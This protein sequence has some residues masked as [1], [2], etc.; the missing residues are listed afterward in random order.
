[1]PKPAHARKAALATNKRSKKHGKQPS[2]REQ[3]QML[4]MAE[5]G[6]GSYVIGAALGRAPNTVHKYITQPLFSDPKF[7]QLV[8]EY[9]SKELID[10]T[11]L[12]IE[13][14]GRLHDLV[15]TMTPIEAIALMDKS[16]TQRRLLEGKSTENIF[17][18]RKII[19]EAH[20]AIQVE[21]TSTIPVRQGASGG[22]RVCI[23]D[24]EHQSSAGA[25]EEAQEEASQPE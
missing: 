25:Q 2:K 20:D 4:A 11:V 22:E 10:L 9:K 18:L 17:S 7:R 1:M 13:A 19:S 14:R 8:E 5:L 16:F 3:A 15:P 12:N 6:Q 23:E 24:S 21:S